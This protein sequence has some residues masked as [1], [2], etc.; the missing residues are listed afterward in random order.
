[1]MD[2]LTREAQ[3]Y[4]G[5]SPDQLVAIYNEAIGRA[6][7]AAEKL[8]VL[9]RGP[10]WRALYREADRYECSIVSRAMLL[11]FC[12]QRGWTLSKRDFGLRTLGRGG[13][14]DGMLFWDQREDT[15]ATLD[16]AEWFRRD[17]KVA[18]ITAHLYGWPRVRRKCEDLAR[19]YSVRLEVPD[20]PSWHFPVPNGTT[21]VVYAGPAGEG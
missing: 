18:A 13:C 10:G 16:H 21:L 5:L 20:F 14:W 6:E 3:Q 15:H 19:R 11:L 1:M 4:R 12:K 7:L 2:D 9:G 8:K 17:R